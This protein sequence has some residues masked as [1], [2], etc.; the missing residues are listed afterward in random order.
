M[1]SSPYDSLIDYTKS[2]VEED[3]EQLHEESSEEV[4]KFYKQSLSK[5]DCFKELEK[6][7]C[8][9]DIFIIQKIRISTSYRTISWE[10]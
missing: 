10:A 3:C 4:C 6:I 1:E 2:A 8:A 9:S 5:I 7:V